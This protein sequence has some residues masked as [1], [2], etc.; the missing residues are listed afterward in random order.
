MGGSHQIQSTTR[1][2]CLRRGADKPCGRSHRH[3]EDT[4]RA[5]GVEGRAGGTY[6]CL[7]AVGHRCESQRRH[8]GVARGTTRDTGLQ[9]LPGACR[10]VEREGQ[11]DHGKRP[12]GINFRSF[13][14]CFAS[15]LVFSQRRDMDSRMYLWICRR[16]TCSAETRQFADICT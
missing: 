7:D 14:K 13:R 16:A 10:E 4:P 11:K 9:T 12:L 6:T 2:T 1:H 8:Q 5:V 15:I 3:G